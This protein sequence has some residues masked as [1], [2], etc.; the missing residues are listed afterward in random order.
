[1]SSNFKNILVTG[2]AGYVGAVLVQLLLKN[3]Y[4]VR[5]LDSLR[6]GG[7]SLIP[8]FSDANFDFIKGDVR[9]E[10]D[11]L[12]S[13]K[14]IDL[15]IHL[16][17]IVGFPACRK[18]PELSRDINVNGTRT[19]VKC[20]KSKIPIIFAS[21]NSVYGK[22]FDAVC[23][24]E[25]QLRPLSEYGIQKAEAE[26]IIRKNNK[27]VIYRFATAFGVSPRLRLD[28]MPNDFTYKAVKE[29]SLIVYEKKFMRTFIHVKDMARSF[30]F[31]LENYSKMK[32]QVY[33]VGDNALN[34]SKED[35]CL[36]VCLLIKKK[37]NYYLHFAEI[38]KDLEQRDYEVSYGKLEKLGFHSSV[39]MEEGIGELIKVVEVLNI[40]DP[41]RNV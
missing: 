22:V 6:F 10:S 9:N 5:V 25:T 30:L 11:V 32:G 14:D 35:V 37:V 8:F 7:A 34:C 27:F 12:R 21:T 28:L 19:L 3:R 24:E 26:K 29:K 23:T 1:M 18:Y 33:N 4:K 15:V 17:A 16:A 13:L 39:T 40:Q 41:Y 31:V 2:G 36:D 20:L 38:N